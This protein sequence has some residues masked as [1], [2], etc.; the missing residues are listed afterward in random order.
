M[1]R[2]LES[3][4]ILPVTIKSAELQSSVPLRIPNGPKYIFIENRGDQSAAGAYKD[5]GMTR[6]GNWFHKLAKPSGTR[7]LNI[8]R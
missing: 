6:D 1:Y 3:S 2:Y 5:T 4:S 8:E 7:F